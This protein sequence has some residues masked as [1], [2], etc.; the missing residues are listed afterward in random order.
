MKRGR[1]SNYEMQFIKDNAPHM[2]YT[3]IADILNREAESVRKVIENLG[4]EINLAKGAQKAAP[5]LKS[6]DFWPMIRLQFSPAEQEFIEAQ[7]EKIY[8][9][10]KEDVTATEEMQ[11]IDTIKLDVL[12]HR[13]LI[14][15]E[16]A[17]QDVLDL[18]Q[19]LTDIKKKKPENRSPDEITRLMQIPSLIQS[20]SA[21]QQAGTKEYQNLQGE[22]NRILKEM[23]STREQRY[24][25]TELSNE[26]VKAWMAELIN[27]DVK[28]DALG[29]HLEKIRLATLDE[30]IRLSAWHKYEDGVVDQ[31]LLTPQN[32]KEGHE[33]T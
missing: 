8:K 29:R 22:K 7:W 3:E 30:E 10:F 4:L 25:K 27:D 20:I 16:Q 28:R 19:E 6:R 24:A 21:A 15:K 32:V 18:R 13:N 5:S 12:M 2:T 11:I 26:S 17:R 33:Q 9:Q 23:K 14:E 31:P 1:Y